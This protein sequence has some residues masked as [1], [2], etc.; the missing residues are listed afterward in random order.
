M[1]ESRLEEWTDV[2]QGAH[3]SSYNTSKFRDLMHRTVLI[4]NN[5]RVPMRVGLKCSHHK[6]EQEKMV[7]VWG[8]R[9]GN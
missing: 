3:T 9:C 1:G 8:D 2:G 5:L 6:Q 4:A 7:T